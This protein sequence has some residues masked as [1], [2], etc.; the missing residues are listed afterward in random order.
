MSKPRILVLGAGL[1]GLSAAWHLQKHKKN[2]LV[3]EKE[4]EIGGL[5]RSK[6]VQGFTFDHDGHLLHFQTPGVQRFVTSLLKDNIVEHKRRAWVY[7][8]DQYVPYPFQTHLSQLP[9]RVKEECL[10]GFLRAIAS[11][12]RKKKTRH[13]HDW[14][15]AT[16]GKG[17]AEHFMVPYNSKFWTVKPDKLTC[18]WL[19]GFMPRPSVS[20][21]ISGAFS[22]SQNGAFGYNARF[23]YPRRG[24]IQ[25]LIAAIAEPLKNI[26]PDAAVTIIDLEKKEVTINGNEKVK[27]DFCISTLPLNEMAHLVLDLPTAV[28]SSLKLL[29]WNS[30]FNL[31]LGF[32]ARGHHNRHWVYFPQEGLSFFRVG[33]PHNFSKKACPGGTNSLY[34]EVAYSPLKPLPRAT[35]IKTIIRDLIKINLLPSEDD[36]RV[37]DA[38]DIIYGYPIYDKN[39]ASARS[40]AINFLRKKQITCCGRYGSWRYLSMEGTI[41][42]AQTTAERM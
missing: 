14:I 30:I 36:I 7:H 26:I 21:V 39:Y 1:A 17:I 34:A 22:A 8:S 4:D 23:W 6:R 18:E 13:F 15:Y 33:F 2:F 24:G 37:S 12:D 9:H 38:N 28:K 11:A 41:L 20:Q 31:N 19:N 3:F 29:R 10:N 32:R 25:A 42:D 16:F 40:K 5:C 27:Y 35:I